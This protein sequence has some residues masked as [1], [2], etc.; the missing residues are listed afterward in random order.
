VKISDDLT[1]D[2]N[3]LKEHE[4]ALS[5]T[6]DAWT[7]PNH[8]AYIAVTVHFEAKG[9]TVSLLLDLVEVATV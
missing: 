4:G 5:F 8:C 1:I 6:T 7:L 3:M 9:Q 2:L